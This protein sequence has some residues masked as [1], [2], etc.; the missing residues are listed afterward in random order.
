YTVDGSRGAPFRGRDSILGANLAGRDA[1]LAKPGPAVVEK[2]RRERGAGLVEGRLHVART[3]LL[4]AVTKQV[5]TTMSVKILHATVGCGEWAK[6]SSST[7]ETKKATFGAGCFWGVEEIFR[8][9]KGVLRTAVGY[10]GGTTR[11]PTYEDVCTDRTGHAEVVQLEY[12]P[13]RIS[14]RDL[15]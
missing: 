2:S 9:L 1:A 8:Q 3:C 4:P 11:N 6:A 10:S 14:Y 15:L 7:M 12:D 5:S 13:A